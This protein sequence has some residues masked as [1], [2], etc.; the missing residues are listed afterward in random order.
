M[1]NSYTQ[2]QLD[3]YQEKHNSESL[4]T[5]LKEGYGTWGGAK[6]YFIK[7]SETEII[8]LD[9]YL[10]KHDFIKNI[11]SVLDFGCGKGDAA[12]S[13]QESYPN[14]AVTK[15]DPALNEF[16]NYPTG[17]FDL[18]LCFLVMHLHDPKEK[19]I[20]AQELINFT[21]RYIIITVLLTEEQKEIEYY[22]YF[23][24]FDIRRSIRWIRHPLPPSHASKHC[25]TLVLEKQNL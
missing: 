21:N 17:K 3:L 22:K 5:P 13:F 9:K 8:R 19:Q 23:S 6:I 14:I 16:K 7:H 20:L 24:G 12:D 2:E 10:E 18:V 1:E 4:R 25:L 15:Y 11:K